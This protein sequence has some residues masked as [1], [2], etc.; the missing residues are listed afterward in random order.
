MEGRKQ[1][2]VMADQP[3]VDILRIENI[4]SGDK[5]FQKE[6]LVTFLDDASQ[7]IAGLEVSLQQMDLKLIQKHA[8][9][10]KSASGNI[11]AKHLYDL[12]LTLEKLGLTQNMLTQKPLDQNVTEAKKIFLSLK[13][14]FESVEQFLN[15]FFLETSRD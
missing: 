15:S 13:K 9:S 11:G 10:L 4:T 8:H 5:A 14:E 7:H 1:I 12:S 2:T 3:P 6:L